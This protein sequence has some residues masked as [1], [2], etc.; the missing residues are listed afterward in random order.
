MVIYAHLVNF[1]EKEKFTKKYYQYF[2]IGVELANDS[3]L[4]TLLCENNRKLFVSVLNRII[5][6]GESSAKT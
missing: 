6:I 4:V 5:N 1:C 2:Q 3:S